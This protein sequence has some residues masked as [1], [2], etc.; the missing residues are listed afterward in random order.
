[1]ARG[2]MTGYLYAPRVRTERG[3]L[4]ARIAV[5]AQL[6]RVRWDHIPRRKEVGEDRPDEAVPHVIERA[7][8]RRSRT[9]SGRLG[10]E[11]ICQSARDAGVGRQQLMR[12]THSPVN[13]SARGS[14]FG[15]RGEQL[16][17]WAGSGLGP[18]GIGRFSLD[19][20]FYFQS[21]HHISRTQ[22]LVFIL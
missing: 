17:E 16:G 20:P 19:L 6:R 15:P 11:P 5:V 21:F 9:V 10:N 2:S 18:T 7:S 4:V 8:T 3:E 14:R 1:M 22:I 13:G 12:G